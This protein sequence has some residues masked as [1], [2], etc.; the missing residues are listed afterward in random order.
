MFAIEVEPGLKLALLRRRDAHALL[1]QVDENRNYLR[2]WMNWLDHTRNI[3]VVEKFIES[4]LQQFANQLG[5]QSGIFYEGNLVG[6][7]GFK[8]IDPVNRIGEIGYWLSKHHQRRGIMSKCVRV[9]VQKG[10]ED[11]GLNKIEIRCAVE[12]HR[13]RAVAQRLGFVQE[14]VLRQQQWLYDHF[15]DH[16]VYSILKS[17]YEA[18]QARSSSDV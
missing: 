12:N 17:E 4:A 6:V 1:A 14:A 11:L 9:L 5:F 7:V 18:L 15:V 3:N 16:T 10:F 2:Q 8:P 13:S